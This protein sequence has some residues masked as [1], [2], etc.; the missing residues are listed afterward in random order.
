VIRSHEQ[1]GGQVVAVCPEELGG[2]GTPR[3]AA[4]LRGGDGRAVLAGSAQVRRVHDG[5]DVTEAFV[6]GARLALREVG[7]VQRAILKAR[8]PSCGVG[9]TYIDGHL[10]DGDGVFAASLRRLDVRLQTEEDL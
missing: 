10:S 8:S 4:D 1:A 9:R 2:L 5:D 3:P 6:R 7:V